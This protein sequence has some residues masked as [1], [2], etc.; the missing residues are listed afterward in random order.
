MMASFLSLFFFTFLVLNGLTFNTKDLKKSKL[1]VVEILNQIKSNP[2][3]ICFQTFV[4]LL[5]EYRKNNILHFVL[6]RFLVNCKKLKKTTCCE[7]VGL[8]IIQSSSICC[9]GESYK[10]TETFFFIKKLAENYIYKMCSF[11]LDYCQYSLRHV[12]EY[13]TQLFFWYSCL[14]F[15][16]FFCYLFTFFLPNVFQLNFGE[17]LCNA[18]VD[19]N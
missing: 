11:A 4:L 5:L 7:K 1:A 17:F 16:H 12:I 19:L 18:A 10:S 9:K 2:Q 6:L 13:G 8:P 15:N 14:R 3:L